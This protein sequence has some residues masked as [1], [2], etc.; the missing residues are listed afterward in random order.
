MKCPNCKGEIPRKERK[1]QTCPACGEPL[2]VARPI[3]LEWSGRASRFTDERGFFFWLII[4]VLFTFLLAALEHL[5][6]KGDLA[7][8][9]DQHKFI[10]VLMFVYIAAHLKLW[11]NINTIMR[12]GYP[13]PYWVDRLIIKN[14]KRG[15]NYMVVLGIIVSLII[16]GPFNIFTLMPAY[17]LIISFFTA[18]FWSAQSFRMDDK[19][20]L[21]GKVQSYF[22]YLGVRRLRQW[23]KAGGAYLIALVVS[24]GIFY[25]LSH[26]PGLWWLIKENPTL[27]EIIDLFNALFSWVPMVIPEK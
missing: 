10:S 14:F 9:L 23:R 24:A 27:N 5:F 4:F 26:V 22:E 8:L 18:F 12:P 21:D 19:E 3:L 16:L 15:T 25:G 6:G 2:P 11:R 13:A 17:I 1:R 7:R 20:F